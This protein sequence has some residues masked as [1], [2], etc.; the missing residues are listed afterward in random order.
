MDIINAKIF[1]MDGPCIENG[2]V[3]MENGLVRAVGPMRVYDGGEDAETLDAGGGM[4][5]PGFVDAHTH[6]GM[7]EDGLGFEGDDGNEDTDPSTP[8]LRAVDAVNPLDR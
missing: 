7:W 3:R 6:M 4:L 5:L 2:Y 8:Q 1:P